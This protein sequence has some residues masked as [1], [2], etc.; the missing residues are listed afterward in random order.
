VSNP[1]TGDCSCPAGTIDR[2]FRVMVDG[3]AGL[4]GSTL[5][6]CTL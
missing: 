2:V 5:H 1:R 4:Y 3:G 6:L